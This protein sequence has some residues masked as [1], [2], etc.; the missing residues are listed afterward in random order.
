MFRVRSAEL[1]PRVLPEQSAEV[2][3]LNTCTPTPLHPA[4][5]GLPKD[6]RELPLRRFLRYYS[7]L[8]TLGYRLNNWRGGTNKH[9][10]VSSSSANSFTLFC[11]T[12][13]P[14]NDFYMPLPT[15]SHH[16][17]CLQS[18]ALLTLAAMSF[19]AGSRPNHSLNSSLLPLDHD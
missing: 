1:F 19:M 11:T 9:Y 13:L 12:F 14:V 2:R 8:W 4:P 7:H 5:C 18:T 16:P 3:P 15:H 6:P 17:P 10:Q